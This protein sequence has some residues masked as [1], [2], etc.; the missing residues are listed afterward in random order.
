MIQ[1]EATYWL[2]STACQQHSE[3]S[4]TVKSQHLFLSLMLAIVS[5]I[6]GDVQ[7]ADS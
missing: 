5:T 3:C 1:S 2:V 4:N 6:V 7:S